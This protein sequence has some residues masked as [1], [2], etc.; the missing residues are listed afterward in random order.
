MLLNLTWALCSWKTET[1][2]IIHLPFCV[3]G[4]IYYKEPSFFRWLGQGSQSHPCLVY[5]LPIPPV[6]I[7]WFINDFNSIPTGQNTC[8]LDL[9]KLELSFSPW[10]DPEFWFIRI[11]ASTQPL[12]MLCW[13]QDKQGSD[14]LPC[15]PP[16]TQRTP[17]QGWSSL[18]IKEK[19]F[20]AWS[21][22]THR[23]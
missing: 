12:L 4:M 20:S 9:I 2:K 21:L 17:F 6:P 22:N 10:L 16:H 7:L 14:I 11:P 1:M 19:L 13:P 23:S 8:Y 18:C 5:L 15:P 3:L